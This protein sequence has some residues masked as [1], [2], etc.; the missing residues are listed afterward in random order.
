MSATWTYEFEGGPHDGETHEMP[1]AFKRCDT[2][3]CN[4]HGVRH[5]VRLRPGKNTLLVN[6]DKPD[7]RGQYA[8]SPPIAEALEGGRLS[9]PVKAAIF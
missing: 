5:Y 6:E 3:V 4:C 2:M 1:V 9:L 8:P 7:E